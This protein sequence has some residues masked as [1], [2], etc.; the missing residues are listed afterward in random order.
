MFY[1][2]VVTIVIVPLLLPTLFGKRGIFTSSPLLWVFKTLSFLHSIYNITI[3]IGDG[4]FD[5]DQ[6][7][8]LPYYCPPQ[9]LIKVHIWYPKRKRLPML[10]MMAWAGSRKLDGRQ[11]W[12][13][14]KNSSTL[15]Q[16]KKKE[17]HFNAGHDMAAIQIPLVVGGND[18]ASFCRCANSSNLFAKNTLW[19]FCNECLCVCVC[20]R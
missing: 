5:Q 9:T 15:S 10:D 19:L 13:R 17:R 20:A 4:S 2:F 16:T 8:V 11:P 12:I 14:K 18:S 3:I 1:L 7:Q 6:S